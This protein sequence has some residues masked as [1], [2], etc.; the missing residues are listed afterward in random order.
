MADA[1]FVDALIA[2]AGAD[3][4]QVGDAV[5]QHHRTD[6]SGVTPVLQA[7]VAAMQTWKPDA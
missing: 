6:W 3:A 1:A 5:P 2:A 4:V 7:L